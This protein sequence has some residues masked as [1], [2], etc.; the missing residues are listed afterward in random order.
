MAGPPGG[1]LVPLSMYLQ[2]S[3]WDGVTFKEINKA[4]YWGR[5]Y[6]KL[7][8]VVG[9]PGVWDICSATNFGLNS[10]VLLKETFA[11]TC[12]FQFSGLSLY[13]N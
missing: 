8:L 12:L 2:G 9:E 13:P 1:L 10:I 3:Q 11:N 6:L 5:C 4:P 7:K